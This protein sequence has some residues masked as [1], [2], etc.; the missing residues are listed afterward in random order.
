M[1]KMPRDVRATRLVLAVALAV[2]VA[3]L[4]VPSSGREWLLCAAALAVGMAWGTVL[5]AW[6]Q[7]RREKKGKKE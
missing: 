1:S 4:L 5:H 6:R 7:W 3:L 2:T